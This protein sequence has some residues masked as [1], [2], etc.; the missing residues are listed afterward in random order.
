MSAVL[1]RVKSK[2]D[3]YLKEMTTKDYTQTYQEFCDLIDKEE[4]LR[5]LLQALVEKNK[6]TDYVWVTVFSYLE[7]NARRTKGAI[8]E[9]MEHFLGWCAEL[10]Q[11]EIKKTYQFPSIME[12]PNKEMY[13]WDLWHSKKHGLK[14]YKMTKLSKTEK[15]EAILAAIK[16]LADERTKKLATIAYCQRGFVIFDEEKNPYWIGEVCK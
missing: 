12:E 10:A 7:L 14:G 6:A 5:G 1:D 4:W 8:H 2:A 3:Q 11:E 13:D 15:I 16:G 9:E